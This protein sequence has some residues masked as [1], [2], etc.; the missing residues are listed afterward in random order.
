MSENSK[1]NEIKTKPVPTSLTENK[2][3]KIDTLPI[4]SSTTHT[5]DKKNK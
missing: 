4:K 3:S 5:Y 2:K 1:E